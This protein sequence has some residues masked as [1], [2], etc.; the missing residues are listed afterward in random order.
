MFR[1]VRFGLTRPVDAEIVALFQGQDLAAES[2]EVQE[3][4]LRPEFAAKVGQVVEAFP[5]GSPRVFVVGLGEAE[6]LTPANL[7]KAFAA[8]LRRVSAARAG[9]VLVRISGLPDQHFAGRCCGE[10]AGMLGWTSKSMNTDASETVDLE[11]G[12][13]DDAFAKGLEFGLS[14][15]ESVNLARTLANTPPNI[16]TPLWMSEQAKALE[17]H[18]LQV[19]VIQGTELEEER[20]TGLINV[21][22]ASENP[23][24]LIRIDYRPDP[25]ADSPVV[26]V[27]KT[28]TYDTGGLSIKGKTG[29]PGM[30]GDKSG[31][32]AVL[33]AMQA[34]ATLIKPDFPVVGILVAAENSISNNAYRPDDVITYRNGKTVE[35]TNTDAEGR[36]VLADGLIWAAE[37]ENPRCVVDIATLT[38]GVVTALGSEF[39][40]YFSTCDDL[41]QSLEKAGELSGDRLWRLPLDENYK[42]MMKSPIADMVNSNLGGA[43]HPVQGATFLWNFVPEGVKWAHLDIAGVSGSKDAGLFT[44]GSSGFGVRLFCDWIAGL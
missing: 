44:G 17:K 39:A 2:P 10:A 29:M 11:I 30:K 19:R 37:I 6:K 18:G 16:A 1:S 36:L 31:G 27:G 32:C 13:S 34:I 43:A 33:G 8:V 15:S 3:A 24:C 9:S 5:A 21:G 41:A 40:G 25:T 35:V 4:I 22:K 26:L 38:G 20:L 23:P 12:A 14:L 42:E 28:I 7:R